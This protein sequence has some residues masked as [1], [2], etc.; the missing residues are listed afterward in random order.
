MSH[1][2]YLF[3]LAR[4]TRE[5]GASLQTPK[6]LLTHICRAVFVALA[7]TTWLAIGDRCGGHIPGRAG[8]VEG[9]GRVLVLVLELTE[10]MCSW[11]SAA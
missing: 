5:A 7:V 8:G 9:C 11:R 6:H 2:F 1:S 3:Q 4:G 10:M